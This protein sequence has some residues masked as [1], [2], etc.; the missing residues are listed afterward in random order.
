M[1]VQKKLSALIDARNDGDDSLVVLEHV[2]NALTNWIFYMGWPR[3]RPTTFNVF[4]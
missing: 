2:L 4:N 3:Y 1:H